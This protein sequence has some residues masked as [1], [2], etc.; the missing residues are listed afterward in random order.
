MSIITEYATFVGTALYFVSGVM[1]TYLFL[2]TLRTSDGIGLLFL[3]F[4]TGGI[5]I[6][7]FTLFIVR[8]LLEYGGFS[9]VD[10]RAIAI[11]NPIVLVS[12]ALYLNY[13]F[14]R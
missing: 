14:H 9:H 5:S 13:L 8:I 7:S 2:R 3:R 10:A 6:S 1:F 11:V 12:I 4:L